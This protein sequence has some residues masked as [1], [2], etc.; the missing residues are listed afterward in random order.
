MNT[1]SNTAKHSRRLVVVST[2]SGLLIFGAAGFAAAA[3][4]GSRPAKHNPVTSVTAATTNSADTVT[5]LDDKGIDAPATSVGATDPSVAP[6][7]SVDDNGVDATVTSVDDNG[8]DATVTSVEAGD[9]KG[10]LRPEGVSDDTVTSNSIDD[11]GVD[12]TENTIEDNHVSHG[13]DDTA[14]TVDNSPAPAPSAPV[15]TVDDHGGK[16]GKGG[17]GGGHGSDD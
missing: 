11:H 17:N 1:T 16:S 12:A 14:T 15:T 4:G 9:D 7:V 5:S 2:I 13:A 10:G 6:V 3:K 8:T